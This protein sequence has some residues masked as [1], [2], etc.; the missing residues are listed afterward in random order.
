[1]SLWII[2]FVFCKTDSTAIIHTGMFNTIPKVK[3]SSDSN[4]LFIKPFSYIVGT[5][6]LIALI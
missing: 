3:L 6:S 5:L 2:A 4:L 1:M